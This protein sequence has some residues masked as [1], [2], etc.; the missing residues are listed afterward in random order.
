MVIY[1]NVAKRYISSI[2]LCKDA[3]A[4]E[5]CDSIDDALVLSECLAVFFKGIF[6]DQHLDCCVIYV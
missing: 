5:V 1:S 6:N 2:R 3:L 4:V